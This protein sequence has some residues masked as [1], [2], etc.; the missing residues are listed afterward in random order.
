MEKTTMT[1]SDELEYID[2]YI[3]QPL[4]KKRQKPLETFSFS[5]IPLNLLVNPISSDGRSFHILRYGEVIR[6]Y[7]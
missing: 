6:A 1:H 7:I 4:K 5:H 3:V 2:K